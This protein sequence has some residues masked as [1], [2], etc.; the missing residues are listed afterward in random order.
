MIPVV[1]CPNC[2]AH[3]ILKLSNTGYVYEC[4]ICGKKEGAEE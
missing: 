2:N 1:I 4:I 3:M